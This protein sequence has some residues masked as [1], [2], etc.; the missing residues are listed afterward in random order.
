MKRYLKELQPS[1][2]EDI[3]AMVAL[4]RPGPMELIPDFIDRKHGRKAITYLHPKLEPI[5]KNTYGIAV[6]Q[7]QVLQIARD[8]AGFTFGEADV[9][10]KAIG[11]KIRELLEEQK[12]KFVEG[13][14]NNGIDV[15][16]GEQ[17]FHFIEPFA[18]YGFNRSHAACYAVI[19]MQTAYLKAR[20]PTEFMTA[21]LN[22]E[23]KDMDRIAFLI[24]ECKTM[25]MPPDIN[26]SEEDFTVVGPVRT[27][28][29][30][31]RPTSNGINNDPDPA[32]NNTVRFG[33]AAVKNV[34]NA[35]VE[36]MIRERRNAGAFQSIEN[37]LER[38][39]MKDLNKKSLESLI[40][41]G[42]FDAF[43][44]RNKLLQN[45]ETLLKYNRERK[46]A[47]ESNQASL[48]QDQ[49]L[50]V[51][52]LRLADTPPVSSAERLQWE[53]ELLGLY[54]SSHPLKQY[55][56]Q[57]SQLPP[58]AQISSKD[59]GRTLYVGGM[60]SSMKK[61]VTKAGEPMAFGNFQDLSGK[62]ELVVF[63]STLKTY[64]TLL[65]SQ[66]ALRVRGRVNEKDGELKL[67]CD[68]VKE[69]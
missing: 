40:R 3:I 38:V 8:L 46:Q 9:L 35:V 20:Y 53:K 62:M 54:I 10:R 63:P 69:L 50:S 2:L 24:D 59:I 4:Y 66:K 23:Q 64:G 31:E 17:L 49:P 37:F 52:S 36:E 45:T 18:R 11:K 65:E 26:E 57:L 33:L 7:E 42:A 34:G 28:G 58:I 25:G 60:M 22:S 55:S 13:V 48:F 19:A 41:A 68:E 12:I 5:L 39:R 1:S 44:E 14:K 27:D 43:D 30:L 16:I 21:L 32:Q 67:I 51:P 6:Y 61:I 15:H 29:R 56:A 47:A